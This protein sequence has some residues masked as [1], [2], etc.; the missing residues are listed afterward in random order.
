MTKYTVTHQWI[1]DTFCIIS[2]LFK[3]ISVPNGNQLGDIN[4]VSHQVES[5]AKQRS[6][7][8]SQ[9]P[10]TDLILRV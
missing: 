6:Q 3:M 7:A 5:L 2:I 10:G 8:S 4:H 9:P 1:L